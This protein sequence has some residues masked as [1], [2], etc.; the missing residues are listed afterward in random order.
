MVIYFIIIENTTI[1]RMSVMQLASIL[2]ADGHEVRIGFHDRLGLDGLRA[3]IDAFP[4]RVVAYSVMTSEYARVASL[5][6]EL[7]ESHDFLAVLGGPHPT[8]F[9]QCVKDDGVD[10]LCRG[11]GDTALPEFCKRLEAGG[12]YWITPNFTVKYKG[13]IH[14]NPLGPLITDLDSLPFPDRGAMYAAEPSL[15]ENEKKMFFSSRGCPYSCTYCF[16]NQY[17][18]IHKGLGPVVRIRSPESMIDEIVQ[19]KIVHP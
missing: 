19:E 2:K 8:F 18:E 3:A 12:E 7:K 5:N 16:N 17:N 1:E 13:E 14:E 4:P 9:P 15:R 11:E 6:R 10:A